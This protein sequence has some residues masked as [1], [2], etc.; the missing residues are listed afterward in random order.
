[1]NYQLYLLLNTKNHQQLWDDISKKIANKLNQIDPELSSLYRSIWQFYYSAPDQ[2]ERA[3]L[4]V[5]RQLFDH[6]F[7]IISPDEEVRLS[8]FYFEKQGDKKNQIHRKER[9]V[10]AANR[11]IKDELTRT[12]LI[13]EAELVL[14]TYRELNKLH[15]RGKLDRNDARRILSS[16]QSLINDWVSAIDISIINVKNNSES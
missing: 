11:Y 8:P 15:K 16:M 14:E 3:A 2:S 6:F 9:L 7:S 13:K 12:I 1:M 4:L 10:Y 5:S